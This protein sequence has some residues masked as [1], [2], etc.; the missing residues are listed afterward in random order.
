MNRQKDALANGMRLENAS[1]GTW[2]KQRST[3][4]AQNRTVSLIVIRLFDVLQLAAPVLIA[5]EISTHLPDLLPVY[6]HCGQCCLC[7][8]KEARQC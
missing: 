6:I 7:R 4:S 3:R 8:S 2:W 5:L 1:W